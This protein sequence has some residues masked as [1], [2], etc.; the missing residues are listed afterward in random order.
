MKKPRKRAIGRANY[1]LDRFTHEKN[2]AER[3]TGFP[4]V[5]R[6]GRFWCQV[7]IAQQSNGQ[8]Y[9][10]GHGGMRKDGEVL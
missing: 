9:T 5:K 10:L 1:M 7:P 8:W 3:E 4:V 2:R 6:N